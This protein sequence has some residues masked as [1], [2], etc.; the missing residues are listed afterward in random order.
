LKFVH[1]VIP[2]NR[3]KDVHHDPN[4]HANVIMIKT[5]KT[6]VDTPSDSFITERM[7]FV[8]VTTELTQAEIAK[9]S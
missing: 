3:N 5:V 1:N 2:S 8:I 6:V 9:S 7:I 4:G